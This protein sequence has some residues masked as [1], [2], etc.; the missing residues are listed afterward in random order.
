MDTIRDQQDYQVSPTKRQK[1]E[2]PFDARKST[3]VPPNDDE[4]SV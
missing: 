1:L 2:L 3:L 4:G